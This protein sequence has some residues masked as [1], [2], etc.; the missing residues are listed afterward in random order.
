MDFN[1]GIKEVNIDE[2]RIFLKKSFL[3]WGVVYPIKVDGKINWKNLLTGG[4]WIKLII[5][6]IFILIIL[7]AVSEVR[8][9]VEVANQCLN[10]TPFLINNYG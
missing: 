3:G 6:I 10:Q 8:N 9:I 4:S 7:G 5:N 2:E 1:K